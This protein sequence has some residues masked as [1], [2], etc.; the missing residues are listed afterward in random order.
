MGDIS[1][2]EPR[3]MLE[4]VKRTPSCHTFLLD[5][6]FKKVETSLTNKVDVD[7][8]KGNRK[9]APFVHRAKG[10]KIIENTGYKTKTYEPPLVAPSKLTT[11]PDILARSPGEMLY[12]PLSPAER[13]VK[14]M[15]EDFQELDEMITRR[16][17]YMAAQALVNGYINVVGDGLN[18]I[19]D[20]GLTNKE[21]ITASTRKWSDHENS[22][23]LADLARYKKQ[24]QIEGYVNADICILG[25]AA[26]EHFLSNKQVKDL[27]DIKHMELAVI[28]PKELPNGV[29]YIG[30]SAKDNMSF[31]SYNEYYLDDFTDPGNPTTK[32]MIPANAVIV[33]SSQANYKKVYSA[34]TILSEDGKKFMTVEGTRIPE[35]YSERNPA[36]QFLQL[37]SCPLPIPVEIDSWYSAIVCDAE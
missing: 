6:F 5:T 2:F 4:V 26:L 16:E 1:I 9:L 17:E 29:T 7:L 36:R 15:S 27:L 32:P 14:K 10:G 35:T 37:N 19:I 21:T 23:P 28:A 34:V 25:S 30:H 31:Y 24:V 12:S 8:K 33:A 13:A 18:E 22:T 20:F 3:R 11:I